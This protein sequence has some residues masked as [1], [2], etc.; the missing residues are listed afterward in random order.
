MPLGIWY[1]YLFAVDPASWRQSLEYAFSPESNS[2]AFF[3]LITVASIFSAVAAVVVAVQSHRQ[4]LRAALV[5]GIV[6][7]AAYAVA[8]SWVLAAVAAMP[9]WWVYKVQHEG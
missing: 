2:R 7:A 8:G 5:G 3:V 4:I 6:Q 9:L 1:L